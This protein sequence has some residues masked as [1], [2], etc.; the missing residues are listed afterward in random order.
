MINKWTKTPFDFTLSVDNCQMDPQYACYDCQPLAIEVKGFTGRAYPG[1][2]EINWQGI[3][4]TGIV[5][6]TLEKLYHEEWKPI[7]NVKTTGDNSFYAATDPQLHDGPNYYRLKTVDF[8]GKE[9]VPVGI[10]EIISAKY[11]P[12]FNAFYDPKTETVALTLP[13]G[14][15]EENQFSLLDG[16]GRLIGNFPIPQKNIE[17][18]TTRFLL[19]PLAA[20][21]YIAKIGPYAK[22]FFKE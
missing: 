11:K 8:D 1:F 7:A 16:T 13:A 15:R 4:E 12:T 6:Y 9:D 19:G 18:I 17:T 2:N 22:K 10:I 3:K 20:G 14:Y 21:M 5:K